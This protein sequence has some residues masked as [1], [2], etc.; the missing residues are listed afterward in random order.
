MPPHR[1]KPRPGCSGQG[2]GGLTLT[3]LRCPK[4]RLHESSRLAPCLGLWHHFPGSLRVPEARTLPSSDGAAYGHAPLAGSIASLT[5][6]SRRPEREKLQREKLREKD[7]LLAGGLQPEAADGV[8][9]ELP[10]VCTSPTRGSSSPRTS[11]IFFPPGKRHDIKGFTR[12]LCHWR[13][14]PGHF[15]LRV[16]G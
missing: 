15:F 8:C 12:R 16:Q 10:A 2:S 11:L 3:P 6:A 7:M 4:L 13:P 14:A 5:G 9:E 1:L